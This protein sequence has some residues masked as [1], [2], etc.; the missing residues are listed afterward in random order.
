M[1]VAALATSEPHVSAMI[2]SV[3]ALDPTSIPLFT[4][5]KRGRFSGS[6][7]GCNF[8]SIPL[9]Q[10]EPSTCSP[11]YM[12]LPQKLS[13]NGKEQDIHTIHEFLGRKI[14]TDCNDI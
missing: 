12:H 10:L 1:N 8:L 14:W 7:T 6:I 4:K 2:S 13:W 9:M 3:R 5:I 11:A